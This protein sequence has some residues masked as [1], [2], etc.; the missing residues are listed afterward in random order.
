MTRVFLD[1]MRNKACEPTSARYGYPH[2]RHVV[3]W[4]RVFAMDRGFSVAHGTLI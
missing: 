4:R 2:R 3:D 1:V